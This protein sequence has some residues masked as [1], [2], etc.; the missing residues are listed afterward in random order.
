[1]PP[2]TYVQ[3]A[4]TRTRILLHNPQRERTRSTLGT[5]RLNRDRHAA[6]LPL[7]SAGFTRTEAGPTGSRLGLAS[8]PKITRG[9]LPRRLLQQDH[10][11]RQP[12][13]SLALPTRSAICVRLQIRGDPLRIDQIAKPH[14]SASK[15]NSVIYQYSRLL[16]KSTCRQR[17]RPKSRQY[18]PKST[19]LRRRRPRC[20]HLPLGIRSVR[21]RR[22]SLDLYRL[23][24]LSCIAILEPRYHSIATVTARFS[25]VAS[26][27]VV[28]NAGPATLDCSPN[29]R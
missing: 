26:G 10:P 11:G 16:G 19:C 28:V 5:V 8:A 13:V 29:R 24:F 23:T 21:C 20:Q 9:P 18:L 3:S 22:C 15:V 1:M 4:P 17:R 7:L 2:R 14:Q 25:T 27:S 12:L 6:K